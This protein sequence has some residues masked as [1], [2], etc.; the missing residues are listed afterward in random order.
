MHR[1]VERSISDIHA[2]GTVG[3]QVNGCVKP[4]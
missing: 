3:E 2:K 4:L 1:P